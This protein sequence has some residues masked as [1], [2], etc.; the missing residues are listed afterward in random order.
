M[1]T[2]KEKQSREFVT[3]L[4]HLSVTEFIGVAQLLGVELWE[5]QNEDSE[6]KPD[7]KEGEI[8]VEEVIEKFGAI[9]K[10][11]QKELLSVLRPVVKNKKKA[12]QDG[13]AAEI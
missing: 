7:L 1:I 5:K 12:K 8:L 13:T 9:N 2:R 6:A 11:K 4:P 3:L 10:H